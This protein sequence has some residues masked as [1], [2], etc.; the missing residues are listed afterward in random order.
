MT[1]EEKRKQW[2]V[3]HVLAGQENKVHDN[4]VKRIKT[5]EMGDYI[6]SIVLPTERVAEIKRGK[7]TETTRKFF[8]GYLIV[9]IPDRRQQAARGQDVYFIRETLA[10]S[11]CRTKDRPIPMRQ[12]EVD[13][14]IAQLQGGEE[15]VKPKIEFAP[16]K[17]S[18][19]DG[20]FQTRA[21]RSRRS[22]PSAASCASA[23]P[24]SA[25]TPSSISNTGRSNGPSY[26][27]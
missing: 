2:Y 18:A 8:P 27:A 25:A 17:S 12:S 19:V 11:I 4:L 10:L 20:P 7:K 13:G 22:I 6:Y 23:F 15:K 16:A 5:E 21:A 9:N 3:V 14:M 24:S 1:D 26:N